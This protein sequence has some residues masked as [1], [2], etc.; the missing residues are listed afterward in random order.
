MPRWMPWPATLMLALLASA[1]RLAVG[2]A[3][4][5]PEPAA[6]AVVIAAACAAALVWGTAGGVIAGVAA[7]TFVSGVPV[8][9]A[10]LEALVTDSY[11]SVTSLASLVLPLFV[12]AVVTLRR[13]VRVHRDAAGRAQ[14]DVLTGL[15]NRVALE[16]HLATWITRGREEGRAGMFAVLFLDLDRFK[17]VNDTY[18]HVMGDRL[19]CAIAR[20]LVEHVRADDLV[21]RLG[22]DEFVVALPGLRD[23]QTAAAIASKLVTLLSAPFD[24]GGKTL[25]VS[26]SIGIAVFPTDGEDVSTLLSSAD[27]AMYS[28]KARGKNSFVFSDLHLRDRQARRLEL[29]RRLRLAVADH[30]L[31]VAYQPQVE[32]ATG[33]V[34][35]FEALLRWDDEELGKVSP[36]E[37]VPVAEDAGLIVP[38]GLW[39]LREA[40]FQARAWDTGEGRDVGVAV[41]V[42]VLQFRQADFVDQ[43]E[44]ALHDSRLDPSRFEIEVTESVL[45]DQFD[46]AVQALRRLHR[47]GVGTALDDFGTGYS[48][49]AYL[50]RL[51]IA[52]LKIDRSFVSCLSITSHGRAGSSV[53]IVDAITAMGRTLGKTVVAEGVETRAQAQYLTRIGVSRAQGFYFGKPLL[54]AEATRL[55]QR[56]RATD[57]AAERAALRSSARVGAHAAHA[58]AGGT[59]PRVELLLD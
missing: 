3:A 33:R 56:Q 11:A 48:S 6:A 35:A 24:L 54:T 51:P 4:A 41:N 37:F 2:P 17:V 40:C 52:S 8:T 25:T 59:T 34:L 42:S 10:G 32:L 46:V 27:T 39:L 15:L 31:Q 9:R 36:A 22:G 55:V 29:E 28:V 53:P 14:Y 7:A 5:L 58:G 12:G 21:A 49:L 30:R 18:G 43:I 23:R 44:A 47:M 13:Q 19:L 50:Q 38:I 57:L 45:I 26:A 16:Q 20:L 1:T